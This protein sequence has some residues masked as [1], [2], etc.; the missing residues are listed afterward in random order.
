MIKFN[1]KHFNVFFVTFLLLN[2]ILKVTL[3]QNLAQTKSRVQILSSEEFHGRG[4]VFEGAD[5]SA[6]YISN[7]LR[8]IGVK[9]FKESY[10]QVFGYSVNTFPDDGY[11]KLNRQ[12]LL[13]GKDYLFGPSSPKISKKYEIFLPDSILLND[14][15]KFEEMLR[16]SEFKNYALIIDY[17]KTKN[18]DIKK[19]YIRK[20]MYNKDFGCI[21]ELIP[22]EL[23]WSVSRFVQTYPVIKIQRGSFDFKSK[24]LK[25]KINSKYFPVFAAKNVIGYI[26]GETDRFIVFTA[27]YDHLGRMGKSVYFP[28]AQDNAS[29]VAM[30]L[31][32][33]DYYS[34]NPPKHSI[35]FI[36]FFGEEAGLLGSRF[37]TQYPFFPLEKI[38]FLI[39]LDLVGTGD[40][41]ITVVNGAE[42]E[43][44]E[45]MRILN[46]INN[47]LD[48][49]PQINK[50]GKSVNSDHAPFN[51]KGVK[52]IFIYSMG[53]KTYY[54]SPK[55]KPETLTF[56]GYESLFKLL[57]EF[58][59]RIEN[60]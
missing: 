37:Y 4:Y 2:F 5:K 41:G 18:L 11:V 59:L 42:E 55:D 36:F 29:G 30:L 14:T 12:K 13:P 46:E 48:L 21:V 24:R 32:L 34:K 54:H 57:T 58:V 43:Y 51:D 44:E 52:G 38:D 27:H 28:G 26:P 56:A 23:M 8:N 31:D 45:Y 6:E 25:I 49:L 17:L 60:K 10:F 7:E 40:E 3:S 16:E 53:G 1:K 22:D 39:N 20:M 15:I 35:A 33:A 50:R 9:A 19:Y 47:E